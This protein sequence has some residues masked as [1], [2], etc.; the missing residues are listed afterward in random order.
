MPEFRT[1]DN[2]RLWYEDQGEG[3]PILCLSGLTRNSTDFDY[4]LPYL[5]GEHRVIRLDY[6]GRGK[7]QRAPDWKTYTVPTETRDVMELLAHLGLDRVA[8][9]GTS[10][11][12]LIAMSLAVLAKDRLTGV[13]LVDIGP[14]LDPKGLEAIT[15]YLGRPPAAA[16]LDEAVAMRASLMAGFEGVPESRWRSE[17]EKHYRETPDG[18]AI[19]YDAKLRDAVL[20][21]GAQPA[22]DLWP[23]FDALGGLPLALIR[24]ANSDLLAPAT[25][26][27]MR[28]RRP[29]M[30]FADVPGRGHVPFLDEPEALEA[31]NEWTMLL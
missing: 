16:T 24:G 21:A 20:E 23:L 26:E 18:L 22:P 7:S 9:L 5:L 25:V 29:D 1:S 10:R 8:V 28:R 11:G 14:E 13:C 19:N 27:E 17:V 6:R 12:G 31:L 15:D 3:E 2:L 30:I 4:V